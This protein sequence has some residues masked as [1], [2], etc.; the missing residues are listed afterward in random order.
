M[1]TPTMSFPHEIA[2]PSELLTKK[3]LARRLKVSEKKIELD[4]QLPRI[5]SGRK[6][7]ALIGERWWAF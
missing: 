2:A 5:R 6:R 7:C 3:E 1:K 4:T